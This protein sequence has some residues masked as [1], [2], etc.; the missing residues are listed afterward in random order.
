MSECPIEDWRHG[1]GWRSVAQRLAVQSPYLC[2]AI[3][4]W[5]I[6]D[7]TDPSS[8]QLLILVAGCGEVEGLTEAR[9]PLYTWQDNGV[10]NV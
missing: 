6:F 10:L 7:M 3:G 1:G 4:Q 2:V 9:S 5:G 8:P